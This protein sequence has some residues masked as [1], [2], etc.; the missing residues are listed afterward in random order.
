[1][2]MRL[3]SE[4]LRSGTIESLMTAPVGDLAS[5]AGKY[6]AAVLFLVVLKCRCLV[7]RLVGSARTRRGS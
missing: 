3:F 6:A 2:S 7:A 5:V 4:E 1:V